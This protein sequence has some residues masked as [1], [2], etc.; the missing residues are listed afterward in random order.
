MRAMPVLIMNRAGEW[1][2]DSVKTECRNA[3]LSTCRPR[4]GKISET[5]LP[6]PPR[7]VNR[8]GDFMSE[9]T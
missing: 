1:L 5:I 3:I 4:L 8:N 9:P 7:G 6:H 2:F